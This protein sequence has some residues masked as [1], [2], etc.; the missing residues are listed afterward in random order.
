[1]KSVSAGSILGL[2]IIIPLAFVI[3]NGWFLPE[4]HY[5]AY[6]F[7]EVIL[8]ELTLSIKNLFINILLLFLPLYLLIHSYINTSIKRA[9]IIIVISSLFVFKD[10]VSSIL[11]WQP[12]EQATQS[13]NNRVYSRYRGGGLGLAK[14]Y[15]ILF[16][17]PSNN[18]KSVKEDL[19]PILRS[20]GFDIDTKSTFFG[21]EAINNLELGEQFT[22]TPQ[23]RNYLSLELSDSNSKK[24]LSKYIYI[25]LGYDSY[26]SGGLKNV[27]PGTIEGFIQLYPRQL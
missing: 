21:D 6:S 18:V 24:F 26:R 14:V 12:L 10:I 20:K 19:V 27:E 16:T 15:N 9:I 4:P 22:I 1:M 8:K 7:S 17:I 23:N 13:Y 11:L 2:L 5:S 3:W 25:H